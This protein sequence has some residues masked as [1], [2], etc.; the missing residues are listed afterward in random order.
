MPTQF[1]PARIGR[2][3][4]AAR[5]TFLEKLG[6]MATRTTGDVLT[7]VGVDRFVGRPA[8]EQQ[9]EHA[10]SMQELQIDAQVRSQ[11]REQAHDTAKQQRLLTQNLMV[12]YQDLI[13]E[14]HTPEDTAIA[15]AYGTQ[16]SGRKDTAFL[17]IADM[18]KTHSDQLAK[19][20]EA[21]A[22]ASNAQDK[23]PTPEGAAALAEATTVFRKLQSNSADL[24]ET[25]DTMQGIQKRLP[26]HAK[27]QA[28]QWSRVPRSHI[29]AL[30]KLQARR[31]RLKKEGIRLRL[32]SIKARYYSLGN[33]ADFDKW[34]NAETLP[35]RLKQ[36]TDRDRAQG[37]PA[38]NALG[39]TLPTASGG[40]TQAPQPAPTGQTT[41]GQTTDPPKLKKGTWEEFESLPADKQRTVLLEV[42]YG[43]DGPLS[44]KSWT[45]AYQPR[46]MSA[47]STTK[48]ARGPKIAD[49]DKLI[50]RQ[51]QAVKNVEALRANDLSLIALETFKEF[52]GANDI[53]S[54]T[55]TPTEKK[56]VSK[57]MSMAIRTHLLGVDPET[58]MD[59]ATKHADEVVQ[60]LFD[61]NKN[62]R[63]MQEL[64]LGEK[65]TGD[66]KEWHGRFILLPLEVRLHLGNLH[67][68]ERWRKRRLIANVYS[69]TDKKKQNRAKR[70]VANTVVSQ[71]A[72][73]AKSLRIT[74]RGD[75]PTV[76]HIIQEW[77]RLYFNN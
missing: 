42:V 63:L 55:I 46:I 51:S 27:S 23:N 37:S 75:V 26:R 53:V 16:A 39:R 3:P 33:Q 14:F 43:K 73:V 52:M 32:N 5:K 67:N 70:Q 18:R 19:Q 69:T 62:I 25:T 34:V 41:T 58:G 21:M 35:D 36:Y 9:R 56:E 72:Q 11:A 15:K 40:T 13:K 4:K 50:G 29:N 8:R 28:V 38:T 20:A 12:E 30:K 68:A 60:L 64:A 6:D 59:R 44:D 54:Q 57:L 45:A 74:V 76:D 22:D 24:E 71:L 10:R 48:R 17:T 77:D 61:S 7:N 47:L 49:L 66:L 1:A 65:E 2:D 31:E